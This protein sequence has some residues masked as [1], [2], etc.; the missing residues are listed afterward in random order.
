MTLRQ[1]LSHRAGLISFKEDGE[2][3]SVIATYKK[4]I[5]ENTG[6]AQRRYHCIAHILTYEPQDSDLPR[7]RFYSNTGFMAA[8]LMLEKVTNKTWELLIMEMSDELG[9]GIHIGWPVKFNQ[10]QPRGHVNPQ[11]WLLE[12]EED[13]VKEFGL[14]TSPSGNISI[15]V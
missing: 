7:S 2:V 14:L 1:L 9:L 12:S 15:S 8:G 6:P 5:P 10:D 3:S 4:G 13:L 11:K